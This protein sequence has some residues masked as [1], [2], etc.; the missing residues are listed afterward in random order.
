LPKARSSQGQAQLARRVTL[1]ASNNEGL[2]KTYNH[3]HDKYQDDSEI[4]KLRDLHAQMDCAVLD[5]YGWTDLQPVHDF[6]LDSE[7]PEEELESGKTR[8]KKEPWRYRWTDE[9]RDELLARL[10]ELNRQRAKEEKQAAA[11]AKRITPAKPRAPK[12]TKKKPKAT[13]AGQAAF[14]LEPSE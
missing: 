1:T 12:Q 13:G 4:R 9:F 3:F 11:T 6:I 5:A 10:L 7:E 14:D 2:T 8:K